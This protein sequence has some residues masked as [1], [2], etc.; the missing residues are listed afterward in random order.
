MIKA[1][2]LSDN[3]DKCRQKF[4]EYKRNEKKFMLLENK[5]RKQ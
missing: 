5:V 1:N 3:H 2:T 4:E